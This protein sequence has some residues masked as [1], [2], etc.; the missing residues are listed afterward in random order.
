MKQLTPDEKE[1]LDILEGMIM[2]NLTKMAEWAVQPIKERLKQSSY[3][4]GLIKRT[5]M[6]MKCKKDFVALFAEPEEENE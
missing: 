6:L 4:K 5:D 1:Q 2:K 3:I